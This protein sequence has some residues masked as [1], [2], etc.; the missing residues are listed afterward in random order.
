MTNRFTASG[1]RD[2][3]DKPVSICGQY[4]LRAGA[5]VIAVA[6]VAGCCAST[7]ANTSTFLCITEIMYDP[8]TDEPRGEWVEI[9]NAASFPVDISGE[10]LSDLTGPS[11]GSVPSGTVLGGES[12]AVL[13]NDQISKAD[14]RSEWNVPAVALVIPVSWGEL[15]LIE[16]LSFEFDVVAY[17]NGSG[18]PIA[19]DAA[20]IYL[21]DLHLNNG[22]AANWALSTLAVARHPAGTIYA[23]GDLG[24]PGLF[25]VPEPTSLAL[26]GVGGMA[27]LRRRRRAR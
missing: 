2:T 20:S 18:W 16:T 27:L 24:S 25:A 8:A 11:W 26:L 14:F 17:Q 13:I 15:N 22:I 9:Y 21:T 1:V 3:F 10:Q 12:F 7:Q 6:V 19:N 4:K 5:V 23:S